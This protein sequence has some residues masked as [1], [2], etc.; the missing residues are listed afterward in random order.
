M[1][2][3]REVEQKQSSTALIPEEEIVGSSHLENDLTTI[4]SN[5]DMNM[6]DST[7]IREPKSKRSAASSAQREYAQA[8]NVIGSS[9]ARRSAVLTVPTKR[10]RM[11]P[12]LLL[13]DE[14]EEEWLEDDLPSPTRKSSK[15]SNL[16]LPV[17]KP[18]YQSER[19]K[20]PS[21]SSRSSK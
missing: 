21:S 13:E 12:A 7:R 11:Q 15:K 3:S 19:E 18:S 2:S 9:S 6:L 5:D 16:S 14:I 10:S 4:I 17:H 8:M 20:T 1:P